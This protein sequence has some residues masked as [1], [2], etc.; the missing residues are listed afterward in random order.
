V[1]SI[2]FSE[3]RL[4]LTT[5]CRSKSQISSVVGAWLDKAGLP[6]R[7]DARILL[8]PNLNNDLSALTGNSTD[9]RVLAALIEALQQR[10]YTRITVGD[11]PN[12][13]AYRKGV[14]ILA[15]LGVRALCAHYGV[16]CVDLNQTPATP[17][18]VATGTVRVSRL[19]LEADY[20][21]SVPTIKTHAEVGMSCDVKNLMGCVLGKDK[22]LMHADL[23][24]NLVR[25]NET[26]KPHLILVDGL[27]GMEGNG[28]GDGRP[29]RLDLLAAGTDAFA[30]DVL[31]ARLVGLDWQRIPYLQI[32]RQRGRI[33]DET[34]AQASAHEPL[35]LFEPP[36]PRSLVTR[37]LEHRWL[38]SA[39][40][41]TRPIHGSE[42]V[43]RL[44]YRLG[45]MQDVYEQ[46]EPRIE[47]LWLDRSRC[48]ECG[49]C[50]DYCPFELPILET[51][52]D[53]SS[54]C[55]QCLYC[56]QACPHEAI[57]IRGELGYLRRHVARYGD[58]I[59]QAVRVP[60]SS[61]R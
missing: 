1:V 38:A 56:V 26:V 24:A 59:R 17:V 2:A 54:P 15:R 49:V 44:L 31:M 11:G 39:R 4:D 58:M 22:R 14:D 41:L 8:K 20:F 28:P 13:G 9:L 27:I 42:P 33:G 18:Q 34:I 23:A 61:G 19:C 60:A 3:N 7:Q 51:G 21:I 12:I 6:S 57:Q 5:G 10:G 16:E 52:F 36:P 50:L 30:L 35:A 25:L 53:F 45:L 46:A 48:D 55:I 32:A 37:V 47:R 43:R 29:R 40:D